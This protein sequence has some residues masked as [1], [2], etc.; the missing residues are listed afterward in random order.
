MIIIF[1]SL[2]AHGLYHS[3]AEGISEVREDDGDTQAAALLDA[4]IEATAQS[5]DPAWPYSVECSDELRETA[6]SVLENCTDVASGAPADDPDVLHPG[7]VV[8]A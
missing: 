1:A 8:I 2:N 6:T 4:L 3:M 7:D 5:D